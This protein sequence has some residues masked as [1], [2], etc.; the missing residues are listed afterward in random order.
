MMLYITNTFT[1]IIISVPQQTFIN[2]S[3]KKVTSVI[4]RE[5]ICMMKSRMRQNVTIKSAL[6]R[7]SSG[8]SM[9]IPS[10]KNKQISL[11]SISRKIF[12]VAFFLF[13]AIYWTYYLEAAKQ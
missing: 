8:K 12:P 6:H 2:E 10:S 11:D 1:Y 3:A 7:E 4:P 5:E 13:A 9:T